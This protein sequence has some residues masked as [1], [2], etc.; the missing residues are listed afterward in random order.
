MFSLLLQKKI[1]A[2]SRIRSIQDEMIKMATLNKW[3]LIE[4]RLEPD[5]IDIV[6]GLLTDLRF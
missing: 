1:N 2:F 3:L 5:P 4:Q 6:N